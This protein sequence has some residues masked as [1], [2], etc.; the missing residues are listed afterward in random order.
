MTYSPE[1]WQIIKI[2]GTDPHYRVFGSWRGGYTTGD[3]FFCKQWE[4]EE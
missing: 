3:Y 4:T 2:N 1:E